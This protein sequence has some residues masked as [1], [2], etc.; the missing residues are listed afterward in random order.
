LSGRR[1]LVTRAP[2]G[3][4]RL[5]ELLRGAGAEI[6]QIPLI[7]FAPP[8]SWDPFDRA[9]DRLDAFHLV[10]FTSVT[11]VEWFFRRLRER[12]ISSKP[13]LRIPMAAVGAK[14]A[15]A[16]LSRGLRVEIVP[17]AF[18]AEGLLEALTTTDISGKEILFPRAQEARELLVEDLTRRG[19]RVTLVPVYRTV[20]ADENRDRLLATLSEGLDL[21]TFTA[22]S[23]V[24]H[25]VELIGSG[26]LAEIRGRIGI[27]CIGPVT[28]DAA[29]AH[30]LGPPILPCRSTLE[31]LVAAIAQSL[32]PRPAAAPGS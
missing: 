15:E 16:L 13:L 9:A 26:R 6:V 31:D 14:T 28:A 25:F 18:R 24:N 21:V 10:L 30:G 27:A 7:R 4:D 11:A 20:R 23:T 29:R 8:D 2:E 5:S 19:A 17:E 32:G 12:E 3:G 1:I 22:T